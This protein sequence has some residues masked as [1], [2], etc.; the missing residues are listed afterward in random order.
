MTIISLGHSDIRNENARLEA[1]FDLMDF[2]AAQ[3][4]STDEFTILLLCIASSFTFILEGRVAD[5]K[6]QAYEQ[7]VLAYSKHLLELMKKQSQS[8]TFVKKE[9]FCNIIKDQCFSNGIVLIND[10]FST[11]V[12]TPP[13]SVDHENK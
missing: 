1:I 8:T 9:E 12:Q 10:L 4:I 7:N 6:S 11:F 2:N 13:T 3:K 5:D